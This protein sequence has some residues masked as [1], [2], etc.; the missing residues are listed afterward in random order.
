M[1]LIKIFFFLGKIQFI[2]IF[3]GVISLFLRVYFCH[4]SRIS[5]STTE[6]ETVSRKPC[7][8]F[9][10]TNN[11][12][13]TSNTFGIKLANKNNFEEND[14]SQASS[15]MSSLDSSTQP[16]QTT[17][18]SLC[19]LFFFLIIISSLRIML[20]K[21]FCSGIFKKNLIFV[22]SKTKN[23]IK[24]YKNVYFYLY[25]IDISAKIFRKLWFSIQSLFQVLF[26]DD[27]GIVVCFWPL[28]TSYW[29]QYWIH[30]NT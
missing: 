6:E 8:S 24:I 27:S 2:N 10:I 20:K 14:E 13:F 19:L 16:L 21:Y 7:L 22:C 29:I 4:N 18:V 11:N 12:M 1:Q 17:L 9:N 26:E 25:Q 30:K 3:F 5:P 23:W 15:A 28:E